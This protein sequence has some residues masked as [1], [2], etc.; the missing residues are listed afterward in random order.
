MR[1][2]NAAY[3]GGNVLDG[4]L[5]EVGGG[6]KKA[7]PVGPFGLAKLQAAVFLGRAN[8]AVGPNDTK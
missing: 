1:R 4:A 6:K 8:V 5:H 7:G 3:G 2:P